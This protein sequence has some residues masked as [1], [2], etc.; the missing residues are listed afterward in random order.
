MDNSKKSLKSIN[1]EFH[2]IDRSNEDFQKLA[3]HVA[4]FES[5]RIRFLEMIFRSMRFSA[6]DAKYFVSKVP[7][8]RK[9]G[10][11]FGERV[12][13]RRSARLKESSIHV[14]SPNFPDDKSL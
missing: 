8:C 6:Y 3:G 5:R 13:S 1:G 11:L 7:K 10:R 14:Q 2:E 9:R 4:R 12:L